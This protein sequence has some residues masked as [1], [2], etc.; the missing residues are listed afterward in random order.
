MVLP[1][2]G[3]REITFRAKALPHS[4]TRFLRRAFA[5]NVVDRV[6]R[7]S[8]VHQPLYIYL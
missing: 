7:I 8:V 2:C 3:I 5:P 4:E 6:F 1:I